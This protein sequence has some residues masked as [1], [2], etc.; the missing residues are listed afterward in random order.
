L[1]SVGDGAKRRC[2]AAAA[3]LRGVGRQASG[4]AEEHA[5]VSSVGVWLRVR[6]MAARY[7]CVFMAGG[8]GTFTCGI[9]SVGVGAGWCI[10]LPPTFSMFRL[11]WTYQK[12]QHFQF[13][14]A[15][16]NRRMPETLCSLPSYG[17][18]LTSHYHLFCAQPLSQA[19]ASGTPGY[20]LLATRRA[21]RRL[22]RMTNHRSAKAASACYGGDRRVERRRAAA[23]GLCNICGC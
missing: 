21:A 9:V 3:P 23:G 18:L 16:F 12:V 20:S 22:L 6:R 14:P 4:T 7:Q 19:G 10:L 1:V 13:S 17:C 15:L 2:G 5:I 11:T 8:T